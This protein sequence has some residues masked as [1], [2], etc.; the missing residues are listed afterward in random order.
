MG[1]V[2]TQTKRV[3]HVQINGEEV[4]SGQLSTKATG[5]LNGAYKNHLIIATCSSEQ[6]TKNWIDVR[7][8]IFIDNERAATLTF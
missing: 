2:N 3:L 1:L 7:C 4:I 6:K 5:E 8:M